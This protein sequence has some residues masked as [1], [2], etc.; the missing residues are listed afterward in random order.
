MTP[1][2]PSRFFL[3]YIFVFRFAF[4][5]KTLTITA[6]AR[7]DLLEFEPALR[8]AGRDWRLTEV[9]GEVVVGILG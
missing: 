4:C 6:S 8:H 7:L 1:V 3:W 9:H 2:F 5:W